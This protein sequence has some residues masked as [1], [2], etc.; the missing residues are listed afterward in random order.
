MAET[1]GDFMSATIRWREKPPQSF[2]KSHCMSRK[3]VIG[4]ILIV[5][6]FPWLVAKQC[7]GEGYQKRGL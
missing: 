7:F 5:H 6:S 1:L 3:T 2:D 4:V